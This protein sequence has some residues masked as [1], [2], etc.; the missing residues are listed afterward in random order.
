MRIDSQSGPQSTAPTSVDYL[1]IGHISEDL[2]PDGLVLGGTVCY[3]GL[4]A[5]ALGHSV[6]V[7]SA[8]RREID[9]E[10]IAPLEL[11]IKESPQSTV[12][13]NIYTDSG[14]VQKVHSRAIDLVIEDVPTVWADAGFVHLAPLIG[15][16]SSD[17]LTLF[18]GA[19][20]GLTPQGLMRELG[21]S[22]E[23]IPL[24]WG[25]TNEFLQA[26]DAVV[27]SIAD[28][29]Y[30]HAAV[31]EIADRCKVMVLTDGPDGVHVFLNGVTKSISVPDTRELDATGAGDI[32]AAAFFSRLYRTDNPWTSAKTAIQ[33]AAVSVT[34]KGLSGV[35]TPEEVQNALLQEGE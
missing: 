15:E 32:F 17:I 4:T 11:A 1:L 16:L 34:R 28:L 30:D 24:P 13:E 19:F 26:A 20:I 35:P 14:R 8:A 23:V 9:L 12:F 6:G 31:E 22:G 10:T 29:N 25:A 5:D 7:V 2:T 27:L 3:S 33:L 21:S 18:E